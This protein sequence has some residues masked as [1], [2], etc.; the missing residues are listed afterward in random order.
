MD[1]HSYAMGLAGIVIALAAT[2]TNYKNHR[3]AVGLMILGAI[4]LAFP[5]YSLIFGTRDAAQDA[6]IHVEHAKD[7]SIAPMPV[8]QSPASREFLNP[9]ISPQQ[10]AEMFDDPRVDWLYEGAGER[11]IGKWMRLKGKVGRVNK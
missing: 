8:P 1:K 7:P 4:L 6:M 10:L 3:V 11:Y 9:T 2:F 5:L